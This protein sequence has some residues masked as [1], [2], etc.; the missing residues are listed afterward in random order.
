MSQCSLCSSDVISYDQDFSYCPKCFIYQKNDIKAWSDEGSGWEGDYLAKYLEGEVWRSKVFRDRL[1]LIELLLG[2]AENKKI[3]DIGSAAG[4][5][6]HESVKKGFIT[7]CVEPDAVFRQYSKKINP[8]SNHY[9]NIDSVVTQYNMIVIFDTIGYALDLKAFIEKIDMLLKD[10]G[11]ILISSIVLENGMSKI[12]DKSFN[13]FFENA[14]WEQTLPRYSQMTLFRRFEEAK[15][16]NTQACR[17]QAWWRDYLLLEPA[18]SKMNYVIYQ[19]G[20]K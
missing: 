4:L 11:F 5:F 3:L 15:T 19:K 16:L 12:N 2:S 13:F 20:K 10:G 9:E 8:K 6:I 14:F 17:S 1:N 7:D 18:V